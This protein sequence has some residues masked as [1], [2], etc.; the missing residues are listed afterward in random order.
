MWAIRRYI[1]TGILLF[2]FISLWRNY[3]TSSLLPSSLLD[4]LQLDSGSFPKD[5]FFWRNLEPQFPVTSFRPLPTGTAKTLPPV[6]AKFEPESD[7]DKQLRLSRRGVIKDA[8]SK[9]WTS[10]RKHAWMRDEVGP[11]SGQPKNS[12][13]GWGATLVDAL[14]T[15]WIMDMKP[16]F[17]EAIAAV[18]KNISFA[19]SNTPGISVFETT[20]RYLGGLLAA[21]DL[22]G[23]RRM[24]LK[25]RDV[26]DMLY[27]SFDTPNHLPSLR[28]ELKEAAQKQSQS[29]AQ[30]ALLA[31]IGS[32]SLE[33]TRLSL[34]TGDP[35]YHD[36]VDNIAQLLHRAQM[37]TKVPGL[38]PA[39]INPADEDFD[40]GSFYTL[41][42]MSDSAYE[43]PLKTAA[44][45]GQDSGKWVEMYLESM[46]ASNEYLFFRPMT[47]ENDDIL[48]SGVLHANRNSDGTSVILVPSSGHLTCFL[49]GVLAL[50]SKLLKEESHLALAEK[51]TK[52]CVW[53]YS[54]LPSGVMPEVLELTR[55]ADRNNCPWSESTWHDAVAAANADRAEGKPGSELAQQFKLPKGISK[56][57]DGR[58]V[59]RPEAIESVFVMYRVT[60]DKKWQDIAWK[61]WESIDALTS[62]SR[63]HSAVT[64]VN[65]NHHEGEAADK[66]DVMESYWLGET[67]KYFYLIFS[68]P[69]LINLDD[70]VLTTEAHPLRRFKQGD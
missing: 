61:M 46:K 21:H 6:Q 68:E 44:L 2:V 51:I 19:F 8:F 16:E 3:G 39:F 52:G 7:Q 59:L 34:L 35:K 50:G 66:I 23:D 31:E 42:G 60:G 11:V 14:D 70:W 13:N 38:W 25:A 32:L 67:L 49:G 56:I 20:I 10:Y 9:A 41:G 63:G 40:S 17:E 43:C 48:F 65:A 27:M 29:A 62:T 37:Y 30:V 45:L 54:A 57:N 47:P 22:S 1:L 69:E 18:H 26:G 36:A 4:Q 55:C 28:W 64:N 53:A 24:L 33:F 12:L 58:Y 5:D 15:L